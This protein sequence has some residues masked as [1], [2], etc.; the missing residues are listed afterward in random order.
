[1]LCHRQLT[2]QHSAQTLLI[3]AGANYVLDTVANDEFLAEVEK[4]GQ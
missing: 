1:M 3:C 2:A 4:K